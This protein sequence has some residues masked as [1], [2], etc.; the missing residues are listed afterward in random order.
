MGPSGLNGDQIDSF[1]FGR[2]LSLNFYVFLQLLALAAKSKHYDTLLRQE[3]PI[4][5]DRQYLRQRL[6]SFV[7]LQFLAGPKEQRAGFGGLSLRLIAWVTL[8]GM[9]ALIL[10]H[11][12]VTFLPY[13]REWVV[14]LQRINLFIDLL[15]I[16]F[17]WSRI[18]SNDD[19]IVAI[20]PSVVWRTT[21]TVLVACLVIFSVCIAT[22][23][24]ELVDQL[25]PT[26]RV[27][28]TSWWRWP[29]EKNWTSLHK[30]L[31]AGAPDEV[32]GRPASLFSNRLVLTDQ[33][34]VD[35]DKLDKVDFSRS[36]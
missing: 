11:G 18:N 3:A 33:S 15:V 5:S 23:P 16:W 35:P 28:P 2:A 26:V 17:F 24:G 21:G 6:D 22:Y 4:A 32:L 25:L 9:L 29:S 36:F 12:Q 13:H 34:F 27:V 14:W 8:V 7:V 19:P 20:V 1:Y 10:L 30:L 31:F